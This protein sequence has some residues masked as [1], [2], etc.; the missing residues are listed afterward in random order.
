[1]TKKKIAPYGSWK[2]PITTDLVTANANRIDEVICEQ[3][4]IYWL[5]FRANQSGRQVIVRQTPDGSIAD[6]TPPEYNVRNR[7]HEYGGAS[8]QVFKGVIYFSNFEDQRLY[9]QVPGSDPFPLTPD[10]HDRYADFAL[11]DRH[12]RL[13]CIREHHAESEQ[14]VT[15]SVVAISIDGTSPIEILIKGNDFYSNPR[16]SPDGSLLCWL[17]WNHPNMPWDGCELWVGSFD[18]SG[19]IINV[20]CIAGGQNESV[21]QPEWSPGGDL[22]FIS[23]RSGWW[24]PYRFKDDQMTSLC[25]LQAEFGLPQWVFG[26]STYAFFGTGQLICTYTR[27]GQNRLARLDIP[28]RELRNIPTPY[29]EYSSLCVNNGK[30]LFVGGSIDRPSELVSLD[31]ET[32]SQEI[33]RQTGANLIEKDFISIPQ[34]I[35][36]PSQNHLSA[37]GNFYPPANSDH[38]SAPDEKPPLIVMLHGGPTSEASLALNLKIQFWTSRGFAVLDVNYSGSSGYGRHF[39]LRL[40]GNWGVLDVED[41]IQGANY[42]ATQGLVDGKRMSITGGSAGGFTALCA[43]AFHKTFTAGV[44]RY[45]IGSLETLALDTHK[46]EA[47]YLD[48]LVGPYPVSQAVY[49]QRSPIHFIDQINAPILLMQGSEDKVVPP[50]QSERMFRALVE[51]GLP[52]AYVTFADEQ[53][54]F[55]KAGSIKRALEVELYFYSRIFSFPLTEFI[56]PI[57]IKNL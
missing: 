1:M 42:L 19:K 43:L 6:I 40:N 14:E 24:T 53:H 46:F 4:S 44:S 31:L 23:D 10:S 50:I 38:T 56:E 3:D 51:K 37:F 55:R 8:Y 48:S 45:G 27:S 47:H 52:V 33:F 16:I 29:V 32:G 9:C 15:N 7:V 36:F 22:F 13:I 5:E 28:S 30:I 20:H 57:E 11:D 41:C 21:F 49:Y 12:H 2:S 35:E 18:D 25:D 34:T 17:T 26:L 54:G 39:R